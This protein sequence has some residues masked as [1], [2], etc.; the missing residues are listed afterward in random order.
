MSS[1]GGCAGGNEG[2]N[3]DVAALWKLIEEGLGAFNQSVL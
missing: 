2:M 1:D 3:V